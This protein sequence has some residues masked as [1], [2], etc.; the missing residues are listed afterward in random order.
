MLAFIKEIIF[1]VD[2][3]LIEAD[4]SVRYEKYKQLFRWG[5]ELVN[6]LDYGGSSW[7]FRCL[8]AKYDAGIEIAPQFYRLIN[9]ETPRILAELS[10]NCDLYAC[11]LACKPMTMAKLKATGIAGYFKDILVKPLRLDSRSIAVVEDRNIDYGDC[12]FIKFDYGQHK[13]QTDEADLTITNIGE[14]CL[15]I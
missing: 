3:V 14:L 15:S 10:L 11:S 2:G 7:M 4:G 8:K 13:G 1:D 9:P 5:L 6:S 12:F